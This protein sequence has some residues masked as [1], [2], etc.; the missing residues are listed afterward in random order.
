MNMFMWPLYLAWAN[1]FMMMAWRT[2]DHRR[3]R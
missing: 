2:H 3:I 1:P